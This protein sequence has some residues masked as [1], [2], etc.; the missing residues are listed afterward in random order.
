MKNEKIVVIGGGTGLSS[1]LMGMKRLEDVDLTAIVTVADDG[2]S[3]GRIRD[4]YNVPAVGIFDMFYVQWRMK[5]MK[6]FLQ[7]Y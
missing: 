3:T 7:I 1:M 6:V 5:R 2:G 4:I